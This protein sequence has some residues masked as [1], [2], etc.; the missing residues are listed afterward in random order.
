M[1]SEYFYPLS[2]DEI[3]RRILSWV[4]CD[5]EKSTDGNGD[6][7]FT[8]LSRSA[9]LTLTSAALVNKTF[10]PVAL[11]VLYEHTEFES[12]LHVTDPRLATQWTWCS[13]GQLDNPGITMGT[14]DVSAGTTDHKNSRRSVSDLYLPLSRLL[15]MFECTGRRLPEMGQVRHMFRT[16]AQAAH[17]LLSSFQRPEGYI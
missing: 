8:P 10:S 1:P 5:V 4:A 9:K 17:L 16:C 12:I 13:N 11:D 2:I 15:T 14:G 3:L 7:I 6:S